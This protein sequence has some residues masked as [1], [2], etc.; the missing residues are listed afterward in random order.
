MSVQNALLTGM[1]GNEISKKITG[2][3][4]VCASRTV[5]AVGAGAATG[6]VASGV[7]VVGAVSLGA[8]ALPIV[9]PFTI[10]SAGVA[11]IASLFD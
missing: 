11:G 4:E 8:V 7:V 3:S 1:A 2:T 6:A 5:V 10:V 9:I